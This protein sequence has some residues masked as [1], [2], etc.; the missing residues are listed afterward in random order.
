MWKY[1]I[2]LL[3]ASVLFSTQFVFTKYYQKTKGSGF[4]YSLVFGIIASFVSIP[5]FLAVN[6]FRFEFSSVSF[7]LACVYA[8]V[9]IS[10]SAFSTKALS[11]ANLSFFSLSMLLGAMV[12]PFIYGVCIGETVTA[13]KIIAVVAVTAS[14]FVSPRKNDDKKSSAFAVVCIVA[15]FIL[16]GLSSVIVS[17]HQQKVEEAVS[18]GAFMVLIN[19]SRFA[20]SI[21]ILGVLAIKNKITAG[22]ADGEY[23][24]FAEGNQAVSAVDTETNKKQAAKAWLVAIAVSVGYAVMNGVGNFFLTESAVYVPAVVMYPIVTGG[25]VF[26][27]ALSG[28]IF[29]EKITV[30]TIISIVLVLFGT[31]LMMF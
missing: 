16:N 1:Y 10:L 28:L 27:S 26:F 9:N 17:F 22:R 8:V 31:I 23:R 2:L 18:S 7:A 3:T 20:I 6:K 11:C 21:G 24:S 4:F 13:W 15:V 19:L 12:V 25:G 14:L 30:R 29:G 5:L